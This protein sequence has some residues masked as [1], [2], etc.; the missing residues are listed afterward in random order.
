MVPVFWNQLSWLHLVKGTL[1][2]CFR[3]YSFK[4]ANSDEKG[5]KPDAQ[6]KAEYLYGMPYLLLHGMVCKQVIGVPDR[7]EFL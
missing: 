1:V 5:Y 6:A 2:R 3:N 4:Y 7:N